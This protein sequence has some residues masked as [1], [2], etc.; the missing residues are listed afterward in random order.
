MAQNAQK[1]ILVCP[2]GF[3]RN[4]VQYCK[5]LPRE[6]QLVDSKDIV[7]IMTSRSIELID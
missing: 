7:E 3:S 2:K 5:K 4:T 6:I 1:G